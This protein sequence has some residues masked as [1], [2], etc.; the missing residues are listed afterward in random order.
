MYYQLH[1]EHGLR[2]I[3]EIVIFDE[4]EMTEEILQDRAKDIT[5]RIDE[6][7]KHYKTAR[8]L[9]GRLAA[10]PAKN[11]ARSRPR[12]MCP[13]CRTGLQ[14]GFTSRAM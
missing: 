8:R 2:S 12:A 6:L 9:A 1:A 11:K 7:H 4:E 14:S 10:N 3:K 5:R 13:N